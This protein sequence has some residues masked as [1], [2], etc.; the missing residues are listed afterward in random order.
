M[1]ASVMMMVLMI[2]SRSIKNNPNLTE[3]LILDLWK[4]IS[5][6]INFPVVFNVFVRKY[7][8]NLGVFPFKY[9]KIDFKFINS[10]SFH[11]S[12]IKFFN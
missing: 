4:L 6:V 11:R 8:Y 12:K 3:N 9:I 5:L 10:F 1:I 2:E 7:P